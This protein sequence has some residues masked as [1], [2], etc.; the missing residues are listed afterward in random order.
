MVPYT[1]F[2][3]FMVAPGDLGGGHP[4]MYSLA[5]SFHPNRWAEG[6]ESSTGHYHPRRMGVVRRA[7][8]CPSRRDPAVCGR[9]TPS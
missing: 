3:V 6:V 9:A 5:A 4:L 2:A 1:F 8:S 7:P